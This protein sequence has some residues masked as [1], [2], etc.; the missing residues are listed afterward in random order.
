LIETIELKRLRNRG[1]NIEIHF[2]D[3]AS[4]RDC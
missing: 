4:L 3:K 1:T 2:N